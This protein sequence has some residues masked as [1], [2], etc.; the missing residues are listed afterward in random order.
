M[1]SLQSY[2]HFCC[3]GIQKNTS[4]ACDAYFNIILDS[5]TCYFVAKVLTAIRNLE[6]VMVIDLLRTEIFHIELKE[7]KSNIFKPLLFFLSQF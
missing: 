2:F 6:T 3:A 1:Y 4:A 7:R 5:E